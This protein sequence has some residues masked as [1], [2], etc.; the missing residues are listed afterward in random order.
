MKKVLLLVMLSMTMSVTTGCGAKK[1]VKALEEELARCRQKK[2]QLSEAEQAQTG[3]EV[4][5]AESAPE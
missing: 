3:F 1:R 4:A 2:A 5:S